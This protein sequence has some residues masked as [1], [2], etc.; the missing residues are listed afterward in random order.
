M[1]LVQE[2]MVSTDLSGLFLTFHDAT[3]HIWGPFKYL[4]RIAHFQLVIAC[5][6]ELFEITPKNKQLLIEMGNFW[7]IFKWAPHMKGGAMKG[8]KKGH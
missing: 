1:L 5:F 4:P 8:Q 3:F 2:T 7:W 6:L